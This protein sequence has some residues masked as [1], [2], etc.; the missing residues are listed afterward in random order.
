MPKDYSKNKSYFC[1]ARVTK[2]KEDFSFKAYVQLG[3]DASM[4]QKFA[5]K[6]VDFSKKNTARG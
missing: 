6:G 1:A 5:L 3:F 4:E 2:I